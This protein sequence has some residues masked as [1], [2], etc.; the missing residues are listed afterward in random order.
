[1]IIRHDIEPWERLPGESSTKYEAFIVYRDMGHEPEGEPKQK[2]TTARTA[3]ILGK[4]VRMIRQWAHDF[5]WQERAA[6]YDNELQRT[7]LA[8]KKEEI[9]KMQHLHAQYGLALQRKALQALAELPINDMT[10]K[11]ILDFLVQ[12]IDI[13]KKTR[14]ENIGLEG[15]VTTTGSG[16]VVSVA[17]AEENSSGM[18]QLVRSLREARKERDE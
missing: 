3:E 12:G 2:R 10:P 7:K 6:E 18:M 17:D 11:N 15:G 1:M 9:L 5:N 16:A 4:N 13:E 8:A 14:A